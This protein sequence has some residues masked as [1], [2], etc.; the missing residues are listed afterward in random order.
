MSDLAPLPLGVAA[1]E[2]NQEHADVAVTIHA[3]PKRLPLKASWAK[4]ADDERL[5][6][7]KYLTLADLVSLMKVSPLDR[8]LVMKVPGFAD[9]S[10]T[11]QPYQPDLQDRVK[12]GCLRK[13]PRSGLVFASA[14]VTAVAVVGTALGGFLTYE[15]MKFRDSTPFVATMTVGS[16]VTA[17]GSVLGCL[18]G[19][20]EYS[21]W[22]AT[23]LL[24]NRLEEA[25]EQSRKLHRSTRYAF[26]QGR[27]Q[28]GKSEAEDVS[29]RGSLVGNAFAAAVTEQP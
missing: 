21:I 3:A 24:E 20:I 29:G 10:A 7:T 18:G 8:A 5:H 22:L 23:F 26:E 15:E 14:G 25:S 13:L 9:L 27:Q 6:V 17:L 19:R 12:L 2:V 11:G 4:A 28:S 16:V 1:P